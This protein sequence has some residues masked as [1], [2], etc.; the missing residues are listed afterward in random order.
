MMALYGTSTRWTDVGE[1]VFLI[2]LIFGCTAAMSGLKPWWMSVLA[3]LFILLSAFSPLCRKVQIAVCKSVTSP[4]V[5]MSFSRFFFFLVIF[6]LVF[7][8]GFCGLYIYIYIFFSNSNSGK[9]SLQG[10][11]IVRFRAGQARPFASHVSRLPIPERSRAI[12][13][14]T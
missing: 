11:C 12:A 3:L 14:S 13:R 2:G 7:C 4:S 10:K 9:V 1:W 6:Y 8:F 5:L